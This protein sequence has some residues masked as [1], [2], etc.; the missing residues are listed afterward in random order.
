MFLPQSQFLNCLLH[1]GPPTSLTRHGFPNCVLRHGK[2]P[3]QGI[4]AKDE[5][6][7]LEDLAKCG[8]NGGFVVS[9][10]VHMLLAWEEDWNSHWKAT[11]GGKQND[12]QEWVCDNRTLETLGLN[13]L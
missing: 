3:R 12:I 1:H 13:I 9:W 7:A 2:H 10:S 4:W 5:E 8:R 11:F 6:G